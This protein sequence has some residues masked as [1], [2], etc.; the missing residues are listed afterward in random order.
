MQLTHEQGKEYWDRCVTGDWAGCVPSSTTGVSI[1]TSIT[2]G[3]L[4]LLDP[5][6]LPSA[7]RQFYETLD[8]TLVTWANQSGFI[9]K[10]EDGKF[11][12]PLNAFL[13]SPGITDGFLKLFDTEAKF[14]TLDKRT[15]E[16]VILSVGSVWK[17][18]YEIYA[19]SAVAGKVGVPEQAIQTL[20]S[21]KSAESLTPNEVI[22]GMEQHLA[23]FG[24]VAT[25]NDSPASSR[26]RVG[27]FCPYCCQTLSYQRWSNKHRAC[28]CR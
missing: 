22:A 25:Q 28:L 23:N 6:A 3:R 15:R 26:R 9:G 18:S 8:Q 20:A 7:Q 4:P 16:I 11:I 14:T 21:G 19:H 12:G 5:K 1:L 27:C 10:T 17:S 24:T 13:Y 2:S